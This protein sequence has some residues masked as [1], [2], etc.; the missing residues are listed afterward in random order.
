[1][2]T[3]VPR[4]NSMNSNEINMRQQQYKNQQS[5]PQLN[6]AYNPQVHQQ[7]QQRQQM[8]EQSQQSQKVL[9]ILYIDT[10]YPVM[11]SLN[12]TINLMTPELAKKLKIIDLKNLSVNQYPNLVIKYK[13]LPILMT[14]ELSEPI[15]GQENIKKWMATSYSGNSQQNSHQ[16]MQNCNNYN[17][18]KP[19]ISSSDNMY[20]G[21]SMNIFNGFSSQ[22]ESLNGNDM[23]DNFMDGTYENLNFDKKMNMTNEFLKQSNNSSTNDKK[24]DLT[25]RMNHLENQRK[26]INVNN[27]N[28]NVVNIK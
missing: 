4:M 16:T 28:N 19:N 27:Q 14:R 15:I 8:P 2:N 9:G 26:A 1:M 6:R 20:S 18:T 25:Q 12:D 11:K 13:Q 10:K 5:N 24:D 17:T 21:F 23:N 22:Y 7:Y 3:Y